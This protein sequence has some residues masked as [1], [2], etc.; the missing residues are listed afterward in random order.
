MPFSMVK[1]QR[2]KG[3]Q[4]VT[5]KFVRI[6]AWCAHKVG[7]AQHLHPG[8]IAAPGGVGKVGHHLPH[9]LHRAGELDVT[10][11]V[12]IR[13]P[14]LRFLVQLQADTPAVR[15]FL[16]Q[17]HGGQDPS[18]MGCAASSGRLSS[19]AFTEHRPPEA[20]GR[21]PCGTALAATA[22]LSARSTS[23]TARFSSNRAR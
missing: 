8:H 7:L 22:L 2:R 11:E 10:L 1:A 4:A 21:P 15:R 14:L 18:L 9:P 13:S 3:S 5:V 6:R 17:L 20:V 12:G 16:E 19:A 23:R